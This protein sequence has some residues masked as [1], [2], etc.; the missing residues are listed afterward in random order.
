MAQTTPNNRG[1]VEG[2]DESPSPRLRSRAAIHTPLPS[3]L[4]AHLGV[5][6][7]GSRSVDGSRQPC[8]SPVPPNLY[9]HREKLAQN[10]LGGT[11]GRHP[12]RG[13]HLGPC[14][15]PLL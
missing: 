13:G 3:G 8:P 11:A 7:P 6:Y 12:A 2:V 5:R 4:G 10:N 1:R 14:K 9:P 15:A